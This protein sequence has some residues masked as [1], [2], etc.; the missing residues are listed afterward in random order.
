M[1]GSK[2]LRLTMKQRCNQYDR[3][4]ACKGGPNPGLNPIITCMT[5]GK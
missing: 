3:A 5:L 1:K 4:L 2:T